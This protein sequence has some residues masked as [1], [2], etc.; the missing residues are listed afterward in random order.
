M[1][2]NVVN[3][4]IPLYAEG[5]CSK[6]TVSEIKEHLMSC[7]ECSG[8]LK[9]YKSEIPTPDVKIVTPK[10]AFG[11]V[12]LYVIIVSVLIGIV[13][14][15]L[16]LA[17]I[18]NLYGKKI[19]YMK[20]DEV[21]FGYDAAHIAKNNAKDIKSLIVYYYCIESRDNFDKYFSETGFDHFT[22]IKKALTNSDLD[23]SSLS[24][25][26]YDNYKQENDRNCTFSI[27]GDLVCENGKRLGFSLSYIR[28]SVGKYYMTD[29]YVT[30]IPHTNMLY[31]ENICILP[32]NFDYN[33]DLNIESSDKS[34]KYQEEQ[35]NE[36]QQ[37]GEESFEIY[38]TVSD[39]IIPDGIYKSDDGDYIEINGNT[40]TQPRY[41][42]DT[43]TGEKKEDYAHVSYEYQVYDAEI[44]YSDRT[45]HKTVLNTSGNDLEFFA[46][47]ISLFTVYENGSL[48][49]YAFGSEN[50][51]KIS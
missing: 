40:F 48:Y 14:L 16:G 5:L 38:L 41:T 46:N 20:A 2:C 28:L 19:D 35:Y 36:Y 50:E 42:V 51:Y 34:Y 21:F 49:P 15:F 37:S 33:F 17:G 12:R 31:D 8:K 44:V 29:C 7:D 25:D 23:Y 30:P 22:E 10:K 3:D 9:E 1:N 6:E 4:L 43:I 32:A 27:K 18:Y 26:A 13:I 39:I 11:K 47:D 24:L 45:V